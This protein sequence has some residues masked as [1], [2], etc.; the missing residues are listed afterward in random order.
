MLVNEW[1][2]VSITNVL[3]MAECSLEHKKH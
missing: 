1:D 2:L 3:K